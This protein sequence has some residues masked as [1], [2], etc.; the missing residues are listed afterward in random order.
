MKAFI[1]ELMAKGITQEEIDV[2]AKKKPAQLL[3]LSA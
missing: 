3:G 2:M 1:L